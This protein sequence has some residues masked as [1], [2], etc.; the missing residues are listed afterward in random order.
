MTIEM[1]DQWVTGLRFNEIKRNKKMLMLVFNDFFSS[2]NWPR[3]LSRV[4]H[5]SRDF[6]GSDVSLG[7]QCGCHLRLFIEYVCVW[8]TK[9]FN[10]ARILCCSTLYQLTSS[11]KHNYARVPAESTR[12]EAKVGQ[13]CTIQTSCTLMLRLSHAHLCSEH[14]AE[15]DFVNFMAEYHM[16][17]AWKRNL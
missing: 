16:G 8:S 7:S 10:H 2:V 12:C 13:I 14:F 15:C 4:L 9:S 3:L 5:Q 1:I 11:P 17:F 6:L